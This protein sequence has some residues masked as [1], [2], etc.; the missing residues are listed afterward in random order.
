MGIRFVD[1]ETGSREAIER[2]LRHRDLLF[3]DDE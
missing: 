1:L 2:F 3:F